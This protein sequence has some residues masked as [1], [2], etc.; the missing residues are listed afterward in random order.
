[1]FAGNN[2]PFTINPE[3][4]RYINGVIVGVAT[5][6]LFHPI[7]AFRI[8]TLYSEGLNS[9]KTIFNGVSYSLSVTLTKSVIAYPFRE[10][11]EKSAHKRGASDSMSVALSSAM[12]GFMLGFIATPINA[13]KTPLQAYHYNST[14]SAFKF[15]YNT[16]GLK[17]FFNGSLATITRDTVRTGVYFPLFNYI[18]TNWFD[19]KF[20]SSISAGLFAVTISYPFEG[21]RLFRQH[22]KKDYGY[23]HG[24][25]KSL[26]LSPANL[27]SYS[28]SLVRVPLATTMTHMLYLWLK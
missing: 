1:M 15:V 27:K 10:T 7:D 20:I 4:R 25:K 12:T 3:T 28:V 17:G 5:V 16:R 6:G 19:N 9:Y 22:G 13:I 14:I 18:N 2:Y 8:R 21:M 26:S 11:I 24:L 23:L